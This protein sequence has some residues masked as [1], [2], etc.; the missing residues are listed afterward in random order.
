MQSGRGGCTVLPTP[1]GAHTLS[2]FYAALMP[3]SCSVH[4]ALMQRP[5]APRMQRPPPWLALKK[6]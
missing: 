5:D 3:L 2:A 4:A 6:V 1:P